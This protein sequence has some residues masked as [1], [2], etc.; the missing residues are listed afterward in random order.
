[1]L[2]PEEKC[3]TGRMGNTRKD[4]VWVPYSTEEGYEK[5]FCDI[6]LTDGR[7]FGP[8]WPN[9]GQFGI[10]KEPDPAETL[11]VEFPH[12]YQSGYVPEEHVEAIRYWL[13]VE[14]DA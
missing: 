4:A 1:M 2:V 12:D 8:C 3:S 14:I 11:P 13:E 9:A 6:R 10:L 5:D 7:E